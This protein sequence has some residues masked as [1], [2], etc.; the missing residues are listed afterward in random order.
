MAGVTSH[1]VLAEVER[2]PFPEERRNTVFLWEGVTL[3]LGEDELRKTLRGVR[4]HAASGSV[5][6]FL[7]SKCAWSGGVKK[8]TCR[9]KAL[10]S[11][12]SSYP[13]FFYHI[14]VYLRTIFFAKRVRY[15]VNLP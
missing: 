2:H 13:F 11:R 3:Y 8:K 7:T 15:T 6:A 14:L 12:R 9:S 10:P 1:F 4:E 5:L